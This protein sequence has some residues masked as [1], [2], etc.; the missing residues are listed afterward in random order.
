MKLCKNT[1][2]YFGKYKGKTLDE[3]AKI[4]I[5]YVMWLLDEAGYW[6]DK[7]LYSEYLTI[8]QNGNPP[9]DFYY[10]W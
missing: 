4:D 8:Y 6:V 3:V 9:E 5:D 7:E 10:Q 2:L 1:V